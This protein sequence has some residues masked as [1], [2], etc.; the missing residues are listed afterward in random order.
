MTKVASNQ[1]LRKIKVFEANN[2]KKVFL[3]NKMPKKLPKINF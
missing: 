3:F 2:S 1:K